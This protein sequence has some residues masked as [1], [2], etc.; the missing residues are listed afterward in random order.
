M[1]T[2]SG[3]K[4]VNVDLLNGEEC[5]IIQ[6]VIESLLSFSVEEKMRPVAAWH[7]QNWCGWGKRGQVL[8]LVL[9]L[10]LYV[11]LGVI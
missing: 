2:H 8:A 11:T 10:T 3:Y 6:W 1:G 4:L 9:S 7:R 5:G